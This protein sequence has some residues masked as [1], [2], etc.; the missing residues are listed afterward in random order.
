MTPAPPVDGDSVAV[1]SPA[2]N[3]A[4]QAPNLDAVLTPFLAQSVSVASITAIAWRRLS[5]REGE[6]TEDDGPLGGGSDALLLQLTAAEKANAEIVARIPAPPSRGQ[7]RGR[8]V[9]TL[10]SLARQARGLSTGASGDHL[11]IA[12]AHVLEELMVSSGEA[13]DFRGVVML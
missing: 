13:F 9:H 5:A 4:M 11:L 8:R 2:P 10:E 6:A 1:G 12:S 7:L 3:N